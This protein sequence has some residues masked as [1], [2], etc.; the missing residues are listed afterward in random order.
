M[1]EHVSKTSF[2]EVPHFHTCKRD[3][4]PRMYEH[5]SKTSFPEVPHLSDL[6][7]L[8]THFDTCLYMQLTEILSLRLLLSVNLRSDN[9][10]TMV[11]I[12]ENTP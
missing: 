8:S 1:Y 11:S 12:C 3:G 6:R 5:V 9:G 2:P 10:Q 7:N 4:P